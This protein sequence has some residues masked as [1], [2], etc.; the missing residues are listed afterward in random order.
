LEFQI[1]TGGCQ[2]G[3]RG[4][5]AGQFLLA[6]DLAVDRAGNVVIVDTTNSRIQKFSSTGVFLVTWGWGVAGGSGFE[7]CTSS[8]RHG[9]FGA[10]TAQFEYPPGLGLNA[11]GDVYVAGG[12]TSRV[13]KFGL[14]GTTAFTLDDAV[15]DDQDPFNDAIVFSALAPGDY[16]ITETIPAGWH[17][18]AID[19][20]GGSTVNSDPGAGTLSI[21]LGASEDAVCTFQNHVPS[22]TITIRKQTIPASD[23]DFEYASD[24][25]FPDLSGST[26]IHV[27]TW[28]SFGNIE[29]QFSSSKGA[30]V[31]AEGNVYVADRNNDRIQKFDSNGTFVA[32]WGWGVDS[33]A[34]EFQVC[35]GACKPGIRGSGVGQFSLPDGLAV[36]SDGS[37][38]YVV[39]SGNN[40][41]QRFDA[42]G[43]FLGA[44][45][46]MG[47]AEGEFDAPSAIAVDASGD[48]YVTEVNNNRVQKFDAAGNFIRMW[49]MDVG[50]VGVDSCTAGCQAGA[51][52]LAEG[53]MGF[54]IGV[55]ADLAGNVF[56]NDLVGQ[57]VQKFDKDGQ[58]LTLW[59]KDVGGVGVDFCSGN[60]TGAFRGSDGGQF[61]GL[62]AISV[63]GLGHVY[64]ADSSNH[65]I[66]KFANDGT[67]IAAWGWAVDTEA[68]AF[69]ICTPASQPCFAGTFGTGTGQFSSPKSA[70]VDAD[71]NV[72]VIEQTNNRM[73]KFATSATGSFSLDDASPDDNDFFSDATVFQVEAGTYVI[74]ELPSFK[75]QLDSITCSGDGLIGSDLMTAELTITLETDEQADC[76]FSSSLIDQIFRDS[77]E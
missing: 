46:G 21:S 53:Q 38:V 70:A 42:D 75:W 69:E 77:F 10:N 59:G 15:P 18:D 65:R 71:G 11:E 23:T 16:T 49:G 34:G 52:G 63:D 14:A 7:N 19:C 54:P 67:F 8:C 5:E 25:N 61:G 9:A 41:I 55:A 64:V 36:T 22:Q 66:Q 37:L 31:D 68:A 33:F 72:Y 30:A 62:Q 58:F 4:S 44:W 43:N 2:A 17:I 74:S 3:E 47:V 48:I 35:R 32:A 20:V 28:G 50:G 26:Y 73:Q 29:S 39:D 56:V 40:R 76:T 57:R 60:C 6:D 51:V 13:Q 27:T 24:L 1:C 12:L 45:G